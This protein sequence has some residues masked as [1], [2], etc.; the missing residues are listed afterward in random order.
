MSHIQGKKKRREIP[1]QT[2]KRI[3]LSSTFDDNKLNFS[4]IFHTFGNDNSKS[5]ETLRCDRKP[6]KP[7]SKMNILS[8]EHLWTEQRTM[9][10][11]RRYRLQSFRNFMKFKTKRMETERERELAFGAHLFYLV[12][13]EQSVCNGLWIELKTIAFS[14]ISQKTTKNEPIK[15]DS[16]A[17]VWLC[18]FYWRTRSLIPQNEKPKSCYIIYENV[19]H[20]CNH[21]I[22]FFLLLFACVYRIRKQFVPISYQYKLI[23][24]RHIPLMMMPKRKTDTNVDSL[25]YLLLPLDVRQK[26]LNV[27][28]VSMSFLYFFGNEN[29]LSINWIH[30][31]W[32]NAMTK[33][34]IIWR[35]S[36]IFWII[37][38][39]PKYAFGI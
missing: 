6:Q 14:N 35:I 19:A 23:S 20:I 38:S 25:W 12:G 8:V 30:S 31:L 3:V 17:H 29:A 24:K 22:S 39:M 15:T 11:A 13:I 36:I 33:T 18:S 28:C 5:T 10:I 1:R 27:W 7:F 21:I 9:K 34:L 32:L 37:F 16:C 2:Y 4:N 26:I